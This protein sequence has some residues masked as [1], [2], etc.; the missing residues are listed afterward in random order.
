MEMKG[1][2]RN[3]VAMKILAGIK[4]VIRVISKN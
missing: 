2:R 1:L 3:D 4:K